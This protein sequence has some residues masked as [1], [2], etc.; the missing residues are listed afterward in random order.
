MPQSSRNPGP[1]K[2]CQ[3]GYSPSL[4][5]LHIRRTVY[6]HLRTAVLAETARISSCTFPFSGENPL[7]LPIREGGLEIYYFILQHAEA[8]GT[9][10]VIG[11]YAAAIVHDDGYRNSL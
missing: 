1:D 9:D 8:E 10:C 2:D 4:S 11:F 5:C 7:G 6:R 3:T